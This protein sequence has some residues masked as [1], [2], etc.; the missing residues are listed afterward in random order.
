MIFNN[1]ESIEAAL[2]KVEEI[3]KTTGN[4]QDMEYFR[5]HKKRFERMASTIVKKAEPGALILDIGSHY[6]HSSLLLQF[7]GYRVNSMDVGV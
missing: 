7:L 2:L 6:L 3:V 5:F 1:K 4:V